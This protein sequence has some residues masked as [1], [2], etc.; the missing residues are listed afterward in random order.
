MATLHPKKRFGQHFLKSKEII[1]K[2]IELADP[3]SGDTIVEIGPGRGALTLPLA[4]SGARVVAVEFDRDMIDYIRKRLAGY[5]NLEVIGQNFLDFHPDHLGLSRFIL[6]GNLPFNITSPVIDWI[7]GYRHMIERSCLM[8]Q[9][10]MAARMT[11]TPGEKNWSPL[12]IFVQLYFDV[13]HEFDVSPENFQPPPEVISSVIT[14]SPCRPMVIED[15]DRFEKVVRTSFKHRRKLLLNNLVPEIIPRPETARE[16][17]DRLGWPANIRA[18]E[19]STAQFL[20]LTEKIIA[21]KIL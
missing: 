13:K 12:S 1:K 9:R 19:L 11:A 17:F 5:S 3:K 15:P 21:Y 2:I 20:T 14:L 16:I 6:V 4:D 10:E 8:V 7:T 18:E